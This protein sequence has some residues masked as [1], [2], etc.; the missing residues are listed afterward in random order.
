MPTGDRHDPRSIT[1]DRAFVQGE[2]RAMSQLSL[3]CLDRPAAG[4]PL[5]NRRASGSAV[6][7]EF[8]AMNANLGLNPVVAEARYRDLLVEAERARLVAA[9]ENGAGRVARV[10]ALRRRVGV[11]LVHAGQRLQGAR[12]APAGDALASVATLRAAR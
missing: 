8:A 1:S 5:A 12:P 6:P 4:R 10:V 9:A 7:K 3:V 11:A 2:H